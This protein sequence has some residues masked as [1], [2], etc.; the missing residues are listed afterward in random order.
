MEPALASELVQD[1]PAAPAPPADPRDAL[2][3]DVMR[4]YVPRVAE[5]LELQDPRDLELVLEDPG[6]GDPGG[7][8]LELRIRGVA[9]AVSRLQLLGWAI[10]GDPALLRAELVRSFVT[11][12]RELRIRREDAAAA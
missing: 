12:A 10:A 1:L 2:I 3:D 8:I 4:V 9:G 11:I 6:A 5:L 7:V